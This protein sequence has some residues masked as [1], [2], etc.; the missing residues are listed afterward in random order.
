MSSSITLTDE[1]FNE[2]F[3]ALA[4]F[5][6][7]EPLALMETLAALGESQTRRRITDEKT[8]PSGE[9]WPPNAAGTSTLFDT[10][11]NLLNS[12]GSTADATSAEWG[13]TWEHANVHQDGMVIEPKAAASLAFSIGGQM[14]FAKKV[15]VPARP[16]VGL[17]PDNETEMVEVITDFFGVA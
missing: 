14:V 10:G 2:A 15:T 12:V 3:E 1:G 8:A 17:S 9:A 13:A 4:P 7:F 5:F 16:F 11:R 6:A